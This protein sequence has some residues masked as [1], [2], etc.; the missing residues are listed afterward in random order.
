MKKYVLILLSAWL[1]LPLLSR[2]QDIQ[3]KGVQAGARLLPMDNPKRKAQ[4]EPDRPAQFKIAEE[5]T[6]VYGNELRTQLNNT[7]VIRAYKVEQFI[8]EEADVALLEGFKILQVEEISP[9]QYQRFSDVLGQPTTFLQNEEL[10]KQCYFL[11]AMGIHFVNAEDTVTA[12][13]SLECDMVRFYY[14]DENGEPVFQTL[15][16]DPGHD[17]LQSMYSEIFPAIAALDPKPTTETM[18]MQLVQNP[19]HYKV[20][21]GDGWIRIAEKASQQLGEKV[22]VKDICKWNNIAFAKAM[23]NQVYPLKGETVIIGFE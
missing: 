8:S 1:L 20:A 15:N 22:A 16:S 18:G 13:I 6:A 11:P 2:A 7:S 14:Q 12:L 17:L 23:S 9:T 3:P 19:I 4:P 10:L 21:A 5:A